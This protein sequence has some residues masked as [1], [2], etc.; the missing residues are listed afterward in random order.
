MGTSTINGYF[1]QL[2]LFTRGYTFCWCWPHHPLPFGWQRLATRLWLHLQLTLQPYKLIAGRCVSNLTVA[3]KGFLYS[4]MVISLWLEFKL[5]RKYNPF[6]SIHQWC[7]HQKWGSAWPCLISPF[8]NQIN[9]NMIH[10]HI[11][12]AF[13]TFQAQFRWFPKDHSGF[14][15]LRLPHLRRLHVRNWRTKLASEA[16]Q[17]TQLV[18]VEHCDFCDFRCFWKLGGSDSGLR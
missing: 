1:Q 2:C 13:K 11:S 6:V 8:Y 12:C 18:A 4:Q 17:K 9:P 5:S 15:D 14:D 16:Q 3:E 7:S 10:N